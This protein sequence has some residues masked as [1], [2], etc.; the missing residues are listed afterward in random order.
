MPRK[1]RFQRRTG[2]GDDGRRRPAGLPSAM[3]NCST[4]H[5]TC[6]SS[7]GLNAPAS[8]R[9]LRQREWRSGRF[10]CATAT[11]SRCSA[12]LSSAQLRNGSFQSSDCAGGERGS[13]TDV[14]GGRAHTRRQHHEPRGPAPAQDHQRRVGQNAGN[15]RLHLPA[16]YGAHDYL[17]C[18]AVPAPHRSGHGRHG[19][20]VRSG[21]R[22][23]LPCRV[24]PAHHDRVGHDAR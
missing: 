14:A 22:V 17:S 1:T 15:R 12:Q 13:G 9:S 5:S 4:R 7:R 20:V 16:R 8:T 2:A 18:P 6:F 3:R 11:R 10:I 24:R 19:G 23:S 21:D